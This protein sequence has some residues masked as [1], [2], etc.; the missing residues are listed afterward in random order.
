M[1][2]RSFI[3]KNEDWKIFHTFSQLAIDKKLLQNKSNKIG[4]INSVKLANSWTDSINSLVR[5]KHNEQ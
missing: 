3:R 4:R 5:L 1:Q 2:K